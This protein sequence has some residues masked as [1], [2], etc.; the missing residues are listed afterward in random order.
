[1]TEEIIDYY[2]LALFNQASNYNLLDKKDR[3]RSVSDLEKLFFRIVTELS[4]S[5]F[6]EAGAK[7]AS[8]SR[9]ARR[10]LSDARI[11]AFEANP[12]TYKRFSDPE[13]NNTQ[14]IEYTHMALCDY[15][16][17]VT[18]NVR[19]IE[20]RASADGS[21]SLLKSQSADEDNIAVTVNCTRLDSFFDG[22]EADGL[23]IWMDV[24]GANKPVLT[25]A[26]KLF[27]KI[28]ALFIEVQD[29]PLWE[30][31]WLTR[32]VSTYLHSKGLVP[33]ARDF[34]SRYLY[35]ILYVQKD[36]IWQPRVRH[37]LSEHLSYGRPDRV[38][39]SNG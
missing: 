16:G 37:F 14:R 15:T 29:R 38:N 6:V 28:K 19:K 25:G 9:R 13:K 31:Q 2:D 3:L 21:G 8:A 17:D 35:N 30:G 23:T 26:D 7:D 34:Q 5:L 22:H 33:I 10:H 27:P 32:D 1:M 36:I 24:E 20:G 4:P 11:V 39:V 18:F 12:H